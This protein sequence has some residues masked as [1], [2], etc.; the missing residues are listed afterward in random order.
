MFTKYPGNFHT[1][2]IS[3]LQ[4]TSDFSITRIQHNSALSM[5]RVLQGDKNCIIISIIIYTYCY[6]L[7]DYFF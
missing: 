5:L 1:W 2:K 7:A 3:Y 4:N 6:D